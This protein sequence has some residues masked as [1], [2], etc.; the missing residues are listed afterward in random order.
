MHACNANGD[1]QGSCQPCITLDPAVGNGPEQDDILQRKNVVEAL[2]LK[3][4][5]ICM[6]VCIDVRHTCVIRGCGSGAVVILCIQ[7][8]M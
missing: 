1:L 5:N 2:K 4:T 6:H 8:W 7:S 3:K